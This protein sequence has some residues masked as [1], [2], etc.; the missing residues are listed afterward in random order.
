MDK[1]LNTGVKDV[2]REFPQVGA[3]L[4]EYGIGC[5]PC[6]A[7][8]CLLKDVVEIHHLAPE[9]QAQMLARI[10][11]TI[12]PGR[13]IENSAPPAQPAA[14]VR[15]ICYSPPL[16]KLADEHRVIQRWLA[17]VPEIVDNLP[18]R[19]DQLR[20]ILEEAVT[21]IRNYADAY[22]HAKEEKVLFAGFDPEMDIIA[23]MCREHDQ[24]RQ[25][26]RELVQGIETA[27]I[28][29][30]A[31]CLTAHRELLQAHIRKEDEILYP[32]I[33]RGLSDGQVGQLFSRFR[34]VD[35]EFAGEPARQ[36]EFVHRAEQT[37]HAQAGRPRR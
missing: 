2:I 37:L 12:Y 14:A 3:I 6:A 24:A 8:T 10:A 20:P 32:W 33:D 26:V 23:T 1:Y 34:E 36:E 16:Q 9:A 29:V 19:W 22:H 25:L 31:T 13:P 28:A 27:D 11:G 35:R 18:S 21:F 4:D 7:G 15:P 5:V 17:L 30:V